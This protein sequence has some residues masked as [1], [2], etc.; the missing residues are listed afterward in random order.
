MPRVSVIMTVFNAGPYLR[1]AIDSILAQT[2]ADWE[3]IAVENGSTDGSKQVMAGYTDPR[4]RVIDLPEN[5]GRTPALN[6]ALSHATGEYIANLDADDVC[7]AERLEKQLNWLDGHPETGLVG[8]GCDLIDAKGEFLGPYTLAQV[9]DAHDALCWCNPIAHSAA[10]YR[11]QL[12]VDL[13]GYPADI[14]YAQDFALWVAMAG[15]TG[16]AVM[17]E[18]LASLRQHDTNMTATVYRSVRTGEVLRLFLQAGRAGGYSA[19]AQVRARRTVGT[20]RGQFG[21]ALIGEGRVL[22]GLAQFIHGGFLAPRIYL[23]HPTIRR[24][25]GLGLLSDATRPLRRLLGI[26]LSR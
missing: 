3:L 21:L 16:I 2:F 23:D 4:I 10:M 12:A 6:V 19:A 5:I 13:G 9:A 7:V 11:R 22:T 18:V 17:P 1:P 14:V 24:W 26:G 8:S 20:L 25:S 15:H